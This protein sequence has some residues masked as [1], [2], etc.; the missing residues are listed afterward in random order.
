MKDS[1]GIPQS[2]SM[3]ELLQF[4]TQLVHQT[5][6]TFDGVQLHYVCYTQ[7]PS[8]ADL[9]LVGGRTESY[10]LYEE[11]LF[12]FARQ[13][14]DL[15]MMDHRGQGLSERLTPDS[16][17][18]HVNDFYNYTLDLNI[19]IE[20]V[21]SPSKK[22]QVILS[23]S[24]GGCISLDYLLQFKNRVK[25]A[26]LI[27]PMLDILLPAPRWMIKLLATTL[28]HTSLKTSYIP[29]GE[30][31]QPQPFEDNL[32]T[33]DAT[34]YQRYLDTIQNNPE[35]QLGSPSIAWLYEALNTCDEIMQD[36]QKLKTPCLIVQA[37]DD[38]IVD[39]Q[40]QNSFANNQSYMS[41]FV[42]EGAKHQILLEK[43][44]IRN[45]VLEKIIKFY[46]EVIA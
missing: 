5:I 12:D 13:G 3:D 19:F 24:M 22:P 8:I 17:I 2:F 28:Y 43:D 32:L 9:I 21:I 37:S 35:I 26:I 18:G 6:D 20:K 41:L 7:K 45:Q 14:F 10:L 25:G 30:P 36:K 29:F 27:A 44:S 11:T 4:K 23:H 42:A 1:F 39:N 34:R 33:H 40:A 31:Y 46:K 15:Y 16:H 38:R